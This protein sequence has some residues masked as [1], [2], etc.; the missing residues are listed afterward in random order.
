MIITI[1]AKCHLF[2]I[3]DKTIRFWDFRHN[4]QLQIFNGHTDG[5]FVFWIIRRTIRLWDVETSK[6]LH[7]FNG[8]E[9]WACCVDISPLQRNNN[10]DNNKMKNS[11]IVEMDIPFVLDHMIK[12][13]EYG[14]LKQP[15]NSMYSKDMKIV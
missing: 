2:F 12:P 7:V 10:N 1:I 9:K 14:I 6:S 8:H 11:V 3:N 13:F 5:I 15:N 4:K